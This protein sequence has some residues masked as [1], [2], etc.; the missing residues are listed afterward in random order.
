VERF[1]VSKLKTEDRGAFLKEEGYISTLKMSKGK[2]QVPQ[3]PAYLPELTPP[4]PRRGV[5]TW[6]LKQHARAPGSA[7][8]SLARM[9]A[10]WLAG[11]A[12]I[13]SPTQKKR[14]A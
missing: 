5:I 9:Y 3:D 7:I 14:G 13:H 11:S 10:R 2:E 1:P 4:E 12:S 8:I 6:A